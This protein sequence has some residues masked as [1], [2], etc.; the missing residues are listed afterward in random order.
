MEKFPQNQKTSTYENSRLGKFESVDLESLTMS[1]VTPADRAFIY[2]SSG[3]RYMIRHSRSQ[4]APMIYNEKEGGFG[5]GSGRRFGV[6]LDKKEIAKV[7]ERLEYMQ[8]SGENK[9]EG[10]VTSTTIERI[11]VRKGLEEAINEADRSSQGE[12]LGHS[13][14]DLIKQELNKGNRGA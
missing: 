2:T 7:G 14:A 4:G 6:R 5:P 11:E 12:A 13:M 8:Y 10:I 9:Q 3:N 1:D